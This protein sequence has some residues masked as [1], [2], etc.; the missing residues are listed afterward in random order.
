M[1]IQ[2]HK[3]PYKLTVASQQL[4][5]QDLWVVIKSSVKYLTPN[6][7]GEKMV[8][9]ALFPLKEQ[10]NLLMKIIYQVFNL[11]ETMSSW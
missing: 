6:Q 5:V 7:F 4:E 11:K 9:V 10:E 8:E 2:F 3:A 1:N